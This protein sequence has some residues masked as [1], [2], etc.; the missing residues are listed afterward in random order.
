MKT[1]AFKLA[2]LL[3]MIGILYLLSP[4]LYAGYQNYKGVCRPEN[5]IL[6]SD[7]LI[8]RLAEQVNQMDDL[9][10]DNSDENVKNE[11]IL[12]IPYADADEFLAANP[13]CCEISECSQIESGFGY[14]IDKLFGNY[15]HLARA[16]FMA[17]Y[18]DEMGVVRQ[19]T[20]DYTGIIDNCGKITR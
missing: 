13:N 16:K 19:T 17:R 5:R 10:F 4:A 11:G 8:R 12:P 18:K 7:D 20:A 14:F 6:D 9:R 15:G 2:L 3:S 1:S